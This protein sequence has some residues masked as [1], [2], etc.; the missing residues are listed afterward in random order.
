MENA[1]NALIMAA[2]I[3]IAVI[4]ISLGTFMFTSYRNYS[5]EINRNL[6]QNKKEEFNTQFTKYDGDNCTAHEVVTVINLAKDINSKKQYE[7]NQELYI[8]VEVNNIENNISETTEINKLNDFI[9]DNT[10]NKFKCKVN[11]EN[12]LGYVTKII[13]TKIE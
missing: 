7:Q 10:D 8:D 6:S 13:F 11:I 5:T 12:N 4:I 3:V 9:V 1:S 2:S